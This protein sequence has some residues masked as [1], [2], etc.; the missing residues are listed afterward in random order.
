MATHFSLCEII[1]MAIQIEK[2]GYAFYTTLA[3]SVTDEK[4]SVVFKFLA[5]EELKHADIFKGLLNK[6]CDYQPEGA[7]PDEYFSFMKALAFQYVFTKSDQGKA[8]ASKVK[9]VEEGINLGIKA[10]KDA[11]L[12]YE[13]MKRYVKEEDKQIIDEL[14]HEEKQHLI[15]LCELKGGNQ[16]EECKGI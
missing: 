14:I 11:I 7:Y 6:S 8:L 13:E 2:N 4:A 10:E 16:G 12:F 3:E 1:E 5:G 15:R 9:D